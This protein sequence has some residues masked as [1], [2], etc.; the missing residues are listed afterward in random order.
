MT[1]GWRGREACLARMDMAP[2]FRSEAAQVQQGD[3]DA[4]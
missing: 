1:Q 4:A 3:V 2:V